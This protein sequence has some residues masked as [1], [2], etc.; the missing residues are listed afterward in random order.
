M[1]LLIIALLPKPAPPGGTRPIGIFP[2]FIRTMARW[3]RWAVSSD[4]EAKN[5]RDY[6]FGEAGKSCDVCTWRQ[7]LN[8]EYAVE[9]GQSSGFS[10]IDMHR[11]DELVSHKQLVHNA[12]RYG[13]NLRLLRFTLAT[14]C[15]A[16]AIVSADLH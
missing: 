3:T 8:A 6:W 11:A 12:R 10:L 9:I 13:F 16:R 14:Y 15:M 1:A 2:S 7:V 5:P 4:W